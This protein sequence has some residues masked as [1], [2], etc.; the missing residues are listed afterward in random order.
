MSESKKVFFIVNKYSGTGYRD[1]IEG[2]IIEQSIADGMEPTVAFTRGQ[3]HATELARA[4]VAEG[5]DR[6][7]AVGGDGTVNEVARGL[8]GSQTA[9]GILPKGSGNGLARHLGIPIHFGAAL[10]IIGSRMFV[11]M[12]GMMINSHLSVNVSGIGF[13]GHVA[14][15]FGRNGK[16]G[17]AGYAMQ[18]LKEFT[19]FGEFS[20]RAIIDGVEFPLSSFIIAIANASQFGNNARVAPLASI[21]DHQLDVCMIRKVSVFRAIWLV[22]KLFNGTFGGSR[23][24]T[25]YQCQKIELFLERRVAY[26]IDGEPQEESN[27]FTINVLPELLKVIVPEGKENKV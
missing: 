12:D 17:L 21:C 23:H 14:S 7:F 25:T 27:A 22:N 6:V 10:S 16:R 19:S 4:A 15:R 20:G 26:H 1:S 24:V 9:L 3:G 13:D 18:V 5:F 11:R 8:V 2:R